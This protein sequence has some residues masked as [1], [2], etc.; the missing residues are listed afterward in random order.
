MDSK[1]LGYYLICISP[2]ISL[3]VVWI[4]FR[5]IVGYI[6]FSQWVYDWRV[7]LFGMTLANASINGVQVCG[8]LLYL[9]GYRRK[10]EKLAR[11]FFTKLIVLSL[12]VW[13]IVVS[14]FMYTF[15]YHEVILWSMEPDVRGLIIWDHLEFATWILKGVLW[16]IAGVV[17]GLT[18]KP[19]QRY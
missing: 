8:L 10:K 12:I 17:I 7:P 18:S 5:S 2:L 9:I 1:T 16:V 11:S 14:W 4:I 15:Y 19:K 3:L 13:G 6:I